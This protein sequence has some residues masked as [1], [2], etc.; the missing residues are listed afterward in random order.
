MSR[1]NLAEGLKKAGSFGGIFLL[2]DEE[3]T[4]NLVCPSTVSIIPSSSIAIKGF[5]FC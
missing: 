1:L 3:G 4:S 2:R 5:Y